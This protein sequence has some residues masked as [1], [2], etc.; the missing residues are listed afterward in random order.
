MTPQPS[1]LF[2]A[3]GL[4]EAVAHKGWTSNKVIDYAQAA[5][6]IR[7]GVTQTKSFY[8]HWVKASGGWLM[9]QIKESLNLTEEDMAHIRPF[10]DEAVRRCDKLLFAHFNREEGKMQYHIIGFE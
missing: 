1:I 10:S 9:E 3:S 5:D 7:N 6:L 8:E 4:D 2:L